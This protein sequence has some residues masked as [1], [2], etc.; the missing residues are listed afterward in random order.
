MDQGVTC[1]T[2]TY[3]LFKSYAMAMIGVFPFGI[4]ASYACLLIYH[5]KAIMD[6]RRLEV[7]TS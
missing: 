3:L 5:R 6:E 7:R 2:P 4:T 1:D